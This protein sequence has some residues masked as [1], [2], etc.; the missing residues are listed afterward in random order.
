MLTDCVFYYDIRTPSFCYATMRDERD[1][2][3]YARKL[4]R[5]FSGG[6][7]FVNTMRHGDPVPLHTW[8]LED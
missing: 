8:T 4:V 7:V 1:A 6:I 2:K 3:A 5:R